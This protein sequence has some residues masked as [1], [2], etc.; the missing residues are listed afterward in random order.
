MRPT[1]GR[2]LQEV[3][4]GLGS[5]PRQSSTNVIAPNPGGR[6]LQLPPCSL[7]ALDRPLERSPSDAPALST[8]LPLGPD[9]TA[10]SAYR[11]WASSE[12]PV[13]L[14]DNPRCPQDTLAVRWQAERRR[15]DAI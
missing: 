11:P 15:H 1:R 2:Q 8:A 13:A 7:A 12:A 3:H 4:V 6:L 10:R 9:G 14:L 5:W